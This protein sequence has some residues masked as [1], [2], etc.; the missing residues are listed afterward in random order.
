MSDVLSPPLSA[1]AR[2]IVVA[3]R[4]LLEGEGPD[5]VS[6]RRIADRIG[7]KAPS[8]YKHF[9]DKSAVENALI[10]QGMAELA[11]ALEAVEVADGPGDRGADGVV[12]GAEAGDGAGSGVSGAAAGVGSSGAASAGGV[13]DVVR[14]EGRIAALAGA[15]RAYALAHPDLY[16]LMSDRPLDRGALPAG[17]EARA[18]APLV[19]AVGGDADAARAVWG[20]AHGMVALELAGRFPPGA[21]LSGAWTKGCGAFSAHSTAV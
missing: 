3:A 10:A 17:L 2:E 8:L 13:A 21:D 5:A 15:Y 12:G 19:R 18:A 1:R 9:P 16:R 6:M 7:I 20:F 11:E 4:E 14:G